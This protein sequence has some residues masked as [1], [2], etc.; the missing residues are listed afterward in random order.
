MCIL[1]YTKACLPFGDG[2]AVAEQRT[3]RANEEHEPALGPMQITRELFEAHH[4]CLLD[5]SFEFTIK[6]RESS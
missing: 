1:C 4:F 2:K 5:N 6:T 3:G